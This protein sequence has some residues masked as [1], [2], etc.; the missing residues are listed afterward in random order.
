MQVGLIGLGKMG[1]NMALRMCRANIHVIGFDADAKSVDALQNE[2]GF[3]GA[4]SLD[5]ML[6]AFTTP[7]IL[8]LMLPAG[9][10]TA[11]MVDELLFKL[12]AGD[13]V[14]NG[15]NSF[16]K[17]SV[18]QAEKFRGI[19][20]QFVDA[21]ISGG[22]FGLKNGYCIMAGGE[23]TAIKRVERVLNA[24]SPN[25]D[26]WLHCGP[27]GAGHFVK[28]VHNGIEYGM[29]A[30]YAEGFALMSAKREFDLDI[31]AIAE[32]W[33]H[34]SVVQSRLL[35]LTAEFLRS[36]QAL[37]GVAPS[38]PDSGEGRWTAI[39]AIEL[40]VPAP[41]MS[42]ALLTR[43]ASRGHGEYAAKLQAMMRKGFGGHPVIKQEE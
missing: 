27:S 15:G 9:E 39:E 5:A 7:R 1:A 30:A 16:Y 3:D 37:S 25:A 18:E 10:V 34:G 20:V 41:V 19:G 40:G 6:N 14:V 28:M 36:D 17:T 42:L 38:V 2:P 29:M 12:T 24:L 43:F 33:R 31:G 11:R 13:L 22:V 8:W 32:N 21:G 26:Q 35:D 23:S 4:Y